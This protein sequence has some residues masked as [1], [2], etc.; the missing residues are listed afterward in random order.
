[1]TASDNEPKAKSREEFKPD[2]LLAYLR[3]LCRQPPQT[4]R[5]QECANVKTKKK[6]AKLWNALAIKSV[7]SP[8]LLL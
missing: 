1:M 4:V 7:P 3:G 2:F 5:S 6:R 8:S